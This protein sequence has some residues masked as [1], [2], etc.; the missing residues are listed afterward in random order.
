MYEQENLQGGLGGR[1]NKRESMG[2]MKDEKL[3]G[4]RK[5]LR[6][7]EGGGISE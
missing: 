3:G 1:N 7:N 2:R 4:Q 6:R 5:N